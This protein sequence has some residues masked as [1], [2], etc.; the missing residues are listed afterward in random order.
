MPTG[1]IHIQAQTGGVL[2]VAGVFASILAD[3]QVLTE[4]IVT[5][6]N[7]DSAPVTVETPP[8]A[9]SLTPQTDQLP[10]A[11]Y[12][13]TASAPGY[14]PVEINGVQVFEWQTSLVVLDMQ[15]V[16]LTPAGAEPLPTV[17]DIPLHH[18]MD[19]QGEPSSVA[20]IDNCTDER[21]LSQV[22]IPQYITV[23]LGRPAASARNVTVTFKDYIKNVA[24]SEI[25]PTWPEVAL[26]ANIY[27]QIS[28]ALNRVYTEWYLSKGYPFQITNSTSYDQYF[29]YGRNIFENISRIV[30]ELFA[31]YI[32]RPGTVNP[33][34]A[35][36]CDGQQVSCPGLKQWGTVTLANQGYTPYRILTYYYGTNLELVTGT[37][38][39]SIP[40]S[41]PGTALRVGSTGTAVRTIQRQLNRIAKNYPG[42]GTLTVDG[43]F[44]S[45][46]AEVVRRFQRQFGLTADGVVG[47]STWYQIS[48]IYV[49]VKK[50]AELSSEG[51]FP[52]NDSV[53]GTAGS[54]P[55][56]ALRVGS[57][58]NAV[59]QVQYW[60][61]TVRAYVS[62]LPLLT[63]DGVYGSGTAAAVRVFQ[64]WAGLAVDGV[65]GR[66][67]WDALYREF[68]SVLLEE[69]AAL[70]YV[71]QYPGSPLRV[72]STGNAVRTLQFWLAVA[73]TG[74]PGLPAPAV[75]GSYG[76]G[77]A[78]AVRAF[79][80]QFG[81]TVDGVVGP[82]TWNTLREIFTA[83]SQSLVPDAT[84]PGTYP[85]SP[86]RLGS[87]GSA[88]REM[89]YYLYVLSLYYTDL[90]EINFDG[91]FGPATQR[92]VIAFQTLAGV[93]PDGVVGPVTW[94]AL[95]ATYIRLI[96]VEG[97]VRGGVSP[98]Y[99][100]P[101][102]EGSS[103]QAVAWVQQMLGFISLF[104]PA[105]QSPISPTLSG[106]EEGVPEPGPYDFAGL[107][108]RFT[109][110]AV[111]SFQRQFGLPVTGQVDQETW[112]SIVTVFEV[113]NA[114]DLRG[115]AAAADGSWP[116]VVLVPGSFG[117][118]VL[119][120][121]QLLNALAQYYCGLAYTVEDGIFRQGTL[122][123]LERAQR[124]TGQTVTGTVT[125]ETWDALQ[126]ALPPCRDGSCERQCSACEKSRSENND[127]K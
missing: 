36:Y 85:G 40:Q 107:Y 121:Q 97:P 59:R 32:R 58:G 126:A 41:Y 27:C 9:L 47:Y 111:E 53:G 24:C 43:N 10:Y 35:E 105:V 25:Y 65:V 77:T 88:V 38:I 103:G 31:T 82:A 2:P 45:G 16:Q 20:P 17:Y 112:L 70:G 28:L 39:A 6:A 91:Q 119:Q 95:Y 109:V 100:G 98:A 71:T 92:A 64:S 33:Y 94:G 81:L 106:G 55:G 93:T 49:A 3:G 19:P 63:V 44:G 108:S 56:T 122:S 80:Q 51:E 99:T 110:A 90:P 1:A 54:Y 29:V 18:L 42:F 13:V 69:D 11:V 79:Q 72:G 46:T 26:R 104:Y 60:L 30:D 115:E 23:H 57:T 114:E 68:S 118:Y 5:D 102:A 50:L 86:L 8:I 7:G 87:S 4:Q 78:A 123:A 116:G 52:N 76:S 83:V 67:T 117:P 120:L 74:Y 22:V 113:L 125:R 37:N 48:Y 127:W 14:A 66:A 124:S 61:N 12:T 89:Q 15:P 96:T 21:V 84:F 34:Y 101:L 73:A 75:D 62:G